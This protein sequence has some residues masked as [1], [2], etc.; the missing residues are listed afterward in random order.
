L[1][2]DVGEVRARI[3]IVELVSQSVALKK[4]GRSYT[5]LCPFH[6]DRRPSFSVNPEMGR[7][8]CWSC[9]E[10][11]D[12]FNWVMKTQNVEFGEALQILAQKAGITLHA[13][14]PRDHSVRLQQKKAMEEAQAFFRKQLSL[15]KAATAY[16][17]GRGLTVDL[18]AEWE[19]GYSPDSAEGLSM[20]LKK[21]GHRLADC[22]ALFLVDGD[23]SKGYYDKFKNRLMFPIRD[24]RGELVGFGGRVLGD[25]MPKYI[26]SSDTPLYRKSRVLY[27]MNI[28]KEH[29][30]TSDHATLVEGYLDVLACHIAGVKTAVAS[31]GTSVTE[32]HAKLLKRW[33]TSVTILYDSDS[34]GQKAAER[35]STILGAEGLTVRVAVV[36]EGKDPDTLLRNV[37]PEAVRKAA[38]QGLSPLEYRL[39]LL[40]KQFPPAEEEFW[41]H[42]VVAIA[43]EPSAL[44]REKFIANLAPSYPRTRDAIA[45]RRA[46]SRQVEAALINERTRAVAAVPTEYR[47]AQVERTGLRPAESLIFKALL[48]EDLRHEAWSFLNTRKPLLLTL[49]AIK[50]ADFIT[51]SFTA[52]PVGK[53]ALWLDQIENVKAQAVLETLASD[54][55]I[56]V[57]QKGFTD[58]VALLEQKESQREIHQL[59]DEGGD[60]QLQKIHDALQKMKSS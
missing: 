17:E 18:Q 35:A 48:D 40:E 3:D 43:T 7:Y 23:E 29:I 55:Q 60:E 46:L 15:S 13:Q 11:G 42:A 58:S 12:I 37:G 30:R 47:K 20:L 8:V 6:E 5:G 24:E 16:C 2:D 59:R 44:E 34:A 31:L 21:S 1:A 56:V 51:Q 27:G 22:K 10:K 25:G 57:T 26:N 33:C 9:G 28:A 54:D 32:D 49:S 19:L 39:N 14:N 36:P 38:S 50:L 45:A 53:P 52:A 41:K 4:T